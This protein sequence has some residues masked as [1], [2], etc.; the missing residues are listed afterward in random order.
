[1]IGNLVLEYRLRKLEKV[2]AG[3]MPKYFYHG[4]SLENALSILKDGLR[5]GDETN[6]C[7]HPELT[8]SS[9][10]YLTDTIKSA[11]D[12]AD[13]ADEV[14]CAVLRVD[15]SYINPDLLIY[16]RNSFMDELEQADMYDEDEEYD[17][18]E[19]YDVEYE[20]E[21]IDFDHVLPA[22]FSYRGS[23]PAKAIELVWQSDSKLMADALKIFYS[24][25]LKAAIAN[26]DKYKNADLGR[27]DYPSLFKFIVHNKV[28]VISWDNKKLRDI[29]LHLP[30]NILNFEFAKEGYADST[31]MLMDLLPYSCN[32]ADIIKDV[33]DTYGNSISDRN[34]QLMWK[35][36]VKAKQSKY[37]DIIETLP[38]RYLEVGKPFIVKKLYSQ[39]G[40]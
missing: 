12:W 17:G 5:P 9:L 27:Y 15:S 33:A 39:L 19:P 8:D 6:K 40:I 37:I 18:D 4:T 14:S 35:K 21:N 38:K 30:A 13:M 24:N 29:I 10:I 26:W 28:D 34:I 36:F 20:I 31:T 3:K 16:D 7:I 1:M 25:D 32:M 22:E 23:I 11:K 2:V